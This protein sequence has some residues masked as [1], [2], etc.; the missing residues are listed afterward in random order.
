MLL[1]LWLQ[2][3]RCRLLLLCLFGTVVRGHC[4]GGK[5]CVS[6]LCLILLECRSVLLI[7]GSLSS[8]KERLSINKYC[9]TRRFAIQRVWPND[10]MTARASTTCC[11]IDCA[12]RMGKIRNWR[13]TASTQLSIIEK[14]SHEQAD[15]R[16]LPDPDSAHRLQHS[17]V[18]CHPQCNIPALS[19]REQHLAD[20]PRIQSSLLI[21]ISCRYN[22]FCA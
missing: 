5:R 11:M 12:C 6:S 15:K 14:L 22:D 20:V 18:D 13:Q 19:R 16:G 7:S 21:H 4:A 2:V 10:R 1:L 17:G 8:V 9:T 3:Q